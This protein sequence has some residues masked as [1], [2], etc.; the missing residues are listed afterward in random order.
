MKKLILLRHAKSD[1]GNLYLHDHDRPLNERGMR[2]AHMMGE[3]LR[4]KNA[5]IDLIYSSSALRAS[6]TAITIANAIKYPPQL[7]LYS[8]ELYHATPD[9]IAQHIEV[10]NDECES[11][12]IVGHNNGI[13]DFVNSLCEHVTN[14]M[15][16]C[17]MAG[18][19]IETTEWCKFFN[20]TKKCWF[21][22]FPKNKL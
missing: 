11:I 7:V 17:A 21:Y 18:F 10:I 8:K 19:Y 4:D 3:R 12:M 5:Q 13:T 16:T 2:D 14:N 20:A 9:I 1:W 15:P 6:Q 22:D